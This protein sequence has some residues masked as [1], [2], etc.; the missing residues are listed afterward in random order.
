MSAHWYYQVMGTQ[1]GP[2]TGAEL[3]EL[4][5]HHRISPEDLVR[6]GDSGEWLP[7]YRVHGLFEAAANPKHT[8]S[9]HNEH[10]G[11]SPVH[12][13]AGGGEKATKAAGDSGLRTAFSLSKLFGKPAGPAGPAAPSGDAQRP[14]ADQGVELN[15]EDYVKLVDT[16]ADSKTEMPMHADWFCICHGEK[17][18]PLSFRRLRE[19]YSSGE[20]KADSRVWST[21]SP[22]WCRARDVPGLIS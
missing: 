4:A 13:D 10:P 14:P 16:L 6:K 15:S 5:R 22:K 12:E 18:G 3:V 20:L 2:H 8:H 19:L 1:F 7:A 11:P 9:V 21:A 17:L